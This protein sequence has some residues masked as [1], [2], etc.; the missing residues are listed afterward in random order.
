MG[1]L[2]PFLFLTKAPPIRDNG[3]GITQALHPG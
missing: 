3:I 2:L 1:L